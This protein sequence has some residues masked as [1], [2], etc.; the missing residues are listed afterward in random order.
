ML[1]SHPVPYFLPQ[2]RVQPHPRPHVAQDPLQVLQRPKLLR[3]RSQQEL[4]IPVGRKRGLEK[5]LR[6]DVQ[7]K[8]G[9]KLARKIERFEIVFSRF[10][11][12]SE[13]E[14]TAVKDFI[15]KRSSSV[16][17]R[18]VFLLL[19]SPVVRDAEESRECAALKTTQPS[20]KRGWRG[21]HLGT[22]SIAQ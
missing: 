16:K 12:F 1:F 21:S 6:G 13:P 19:T 8:R 22:E 17:V 7:G 5:P 15:M 20:S 14:T 4:G 9:E 2:L 11:P 3:D 10:Q 18:E